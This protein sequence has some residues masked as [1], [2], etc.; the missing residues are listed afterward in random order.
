[1][2]RQWWWLLWVMCWVRPVLGQTPPLIPID[3]VTAE[4]VAYDAAIRDFKVGLFERAARSF[5]EFVA[6]YPNSA[7]KPDAD[8][9][10]GFAEAASEPDRVLAADRLAGFATNYP[11]SP[12][13]VNAVMRAGLAWL[14]AGQAEAALNILATN[15]VPLAKAFAAGEPKLE[16]FSILRTRAEAALR[17]NQG[18]NAINALQLAEGYAVA[19]GPEAV[20]DRLKLLL[21]AQIALGSLPA[22][23]AAGEQLRALTVSAGLTNR[24]PEAVSLLGGVLLRAGERGKAITVYSEN[25]VAGTPADW[26]HEATLQVAEAMLD[27]GDLAAARLPLEAFLAAHGTF[28]RLDR[29]RWLLAQVLFSQYRA[30]QSS[31]T[32]DPSLLVTGEAHLAAALTNTTP[33]LRGEVQWL[34]G[35]FY[36]ESATGTNQ[37]ERA[38]EAFEA[39]VLTLPKSLKQAAARFRLGDV[40]FRQGQPAAAL[41]HY[42]A[43]V[44][45]FYESVPEV[46]AKYGTPAWLMATKAAMAATNS[47]AANQAMEKLVARDPRAEATSTELLQ[48]SQEYV[49]EGMVSRGR[50]LLEQFVARFPDSPLRAELELTIADAL[51]REER[52]PAARAA[53]DRWLSV[54]TNHPRRAWAEFGLAEVLAGSGAATN[55]IE[56]LQ[57]LATRYPNDPQSQTALL[58]LGD[59]YLDQRE[60]GQAEQAYTSVLTNSLWAG[61]PVLQEARLLAAKA[62]LGWKQYARA[63]ERVRELL[64]DKTAPLDL[65]AEGFFTLGQVLLQAPG[66]TNPPLAAVNDA[67]E[68]FTAVVTRFTNSPRVA[69]ARLKMADCYRQLAVKTPGYLVNARELYQRLL[70]PAVSVDPSLRARAKYELGSLCLQDRDVVGRTPAEI[71]ALN[72]EGLRHFEDLALGKTAVLT[73]ELDSDILTAA[74]VEA[75]LLLEIQGEYQKAANLYASMAS[76]LP[77]MGPFWMSRRD[78]LPKQVSP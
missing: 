42:L 78:R 8:E 76:E 49:R 75:G 57:L 26:T 58:K 69:E 30:L 9:R 18:S 71:K 11:G 45:G 27:R 23:V 24:R 15:G 33:E 74:A 54:Y 56:Q 35:L 61:Q 51:R 3:P 19:A 4:K 64:N 34:L 21:E 40:R 10:R 65:L 32:N 29:V 50:G 66:G 73:G 31:L 72:E 28:P 43:V 6:S 14:Q 67:R 77:R 47:A 22:A 53:F 20:F 46:D 55:A 36:W 63:E 13:A 12:L 68:A 16:L 52:W 38:A 7:L 59:N 41:T 2:K 17:L 48:L 44:E 1:M 62:A 70:D 39:A 25:L 37:L 60:F 5:A